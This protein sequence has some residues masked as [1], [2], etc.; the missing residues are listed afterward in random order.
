MKEIAKKKFELPALPEG[1]DE[2]DLDP[3][4]ISNAPEERVTLEYY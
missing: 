4:R 1:D 3:A 2:I